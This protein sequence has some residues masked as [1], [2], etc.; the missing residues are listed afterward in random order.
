[1]GDHLMPSSSPLPQAQFIDITDLS[2]QGYATGA[3][4]GPA[5]FYAGMR[6]FED[7]FAPLSREELFDAVDEIDDSGEGWLERRIRKIKNQ[8]SEGSCVYN[9]LASMAEATSNK[10]F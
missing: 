6:N 9:M 5:E 8:G 1:M 10:Q 3:D 2:Q 7:A 4:F